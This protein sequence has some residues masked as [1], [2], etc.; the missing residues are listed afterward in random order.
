MTQAPIVETQDETQPDPQA[1][2][3]AQA[4]APKRYY[5]F[6]PK[7]PEKMVVL[8]RR[9][10]SFRNGRLDSQTLGLQDSEVE[11]FRT[12][13]ANRMAAHR[14]PEYIVWDGS[15]GDPLLKAILQPLVAEAIAHGA[16]AVGGSDD[17][18]MTQ[19]RLSM[20][21]A[22]DEGDV[23]LVSVDVQ[24][25]LRLSEIASKP[26]RTGAGTLP[27][28]FAPASGMKP[29]AGVSAE[30]LE[31]EQALINARMQGQVEAP[32]APP[33]PATP[34]PGSAWVQPTPPVDPANPF[35]V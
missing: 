25:R 34:E 1:G 29:A 18:K 24:T 12:Q 6:C 13:M 3:R 11:Y 22:G 27:D 21:L 28:Q 16:T 8:P 5:I 15:L 7:E 26:V 10:V 19:I 32:T 2:V 9:V 14:E 20:M 33:A 35:G 30:T 23:E 4:E 31:R 17:L